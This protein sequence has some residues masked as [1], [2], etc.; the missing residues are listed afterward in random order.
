M[1]ADCCDVTANS[2]FTAAS[3]PLH[4]F[5]VH[6]NR[7]S[8]KCHC[9]LDNPCQERAQ[10][11]ESA[12]VDV[13]AHAIPARHATRDY[14]GSL[15]LR[16]PFNAQLTLNVGLSIH[17]ARFDLPI[18]RAAQ[19]QQH[20]ST[21]PL[22][23]RSAWRT[24]YAVR[25]A[26]CSG[27]GGWSLAIIGMRASRACV[28]HVRKPWGRIERCPSVSRYVLKAVTDPLLSAR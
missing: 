11:T 16:A 9:G 1:I 2:S 25:C 12:C 10:Q 15:G 23:H 4:I 13:W 20:Q 17:A 6:T 7:A 14:N 27:R 22:A 19:H 24:H 21:R 8:S 26:R 18:G 28:L 5:T 3:Y